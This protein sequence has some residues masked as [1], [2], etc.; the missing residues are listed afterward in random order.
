[1]AKEKTKL[2]DTNSA[3]SADGAVQYREN[4]KTNEK[5]DA[6]IKANPDRF[7]F[8]NELQF[9]HQ[10]K[11]GNFTH[12][13]FAD[14]VAGFIYGYK[15]FFI[16]AGLNTHLGSPQQK[17]TSTS[18]NTTWPSCERPKSTPK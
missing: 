16:D 17:K 1:M 11:S 14:I 8:F 12:T 15:T 2:N 6:W 18:N 13:D 3:Q 10:F 4:P 5:I 7:K 9:H